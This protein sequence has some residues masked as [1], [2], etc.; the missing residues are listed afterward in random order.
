MPVN[1][2]GEA[3]LEGVLL[4]RTSWMLLGTPR[5]DSFTMSYDPSRLT[6]MMAGTGVASVVR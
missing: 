2:G 1:L 3:G 4:A 6:R 5:V